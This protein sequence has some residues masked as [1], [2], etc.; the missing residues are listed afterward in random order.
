MI[1]DRITLNVL[2]EKQL[3]V[4]Q[5]LI[6]LIAPVGDESG[7][8]SYGAYCDINDKNRFILLGEWRSKKDL[9]YHIRSNRFGVLLGT[10]TLL[11]EPPRIQIHTISQTQGMEVIHAARKNKT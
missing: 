2:P 7:C 9:D 5:T 1:F 4:L 11:S 8:I 10:K 6:S 3:E